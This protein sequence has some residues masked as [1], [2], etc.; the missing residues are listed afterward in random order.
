M[1]YVYAPACK[2]K[3]QLKGADKTYKI[4]KNA[5]LPINY[6]NM[7]P[8]KYEFEV[9]ACNNNDQWNS[10]PRKIQITILPPWWLSLPAKIVYGILFLLLYTAFTDT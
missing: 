3:Y 5:S 7:A 9:Y 2:I 10:H 6:V 4:N 8:G 1:N